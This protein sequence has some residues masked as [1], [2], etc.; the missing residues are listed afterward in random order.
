MGYSGIVTSLGVHWPV[1]NLRRRWPSWEHPLEVWLRPGG[2]TRRR[3]FATA[4][5]SATVSRGFA[6][7]NPLTNT[8]R[9]ANRSSCSEKHLLEHLYPRRKRGPK[10][11][12]LIAR[13]RDRRGRRNLLDGLVSIANRKKI[14]FH[15]LR[16]FDR[17]RSK[18]GK[19]LVTKFSV[20]FFSFFFDV[21][22]SVTFSS[23]EG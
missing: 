7:H 4:A 8:R 3:N 20:F 5:P 22:F 12:L 15:L 11:D 19:R 6:D 10:G 2:W 1:N 23:L 18:Q 21:F 9:G 14:N 16:S 13:E 17:V